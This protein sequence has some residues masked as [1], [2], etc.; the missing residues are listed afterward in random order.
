M[1]TP[2]QRFMFSSK[3]AGLL[4]QT[5]ALDPDSLDP[6]SLD[7]DLFDLEPL[8]K[9]REIDTPQPICELACPLSTSG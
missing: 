6:D 3:F 9:T 8:V 7:P 4:E 5:G 2:E 1:D